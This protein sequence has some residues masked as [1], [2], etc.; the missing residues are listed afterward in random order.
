MFPHLLL[1][2][3]SVLLVRVSALIARLEESVSCPNQPEAVLKDT[4]CSGAF[5]LQV[6]IIFGFLEIFPPRHETFPTV[7]VFWPPR[8]FIKCGH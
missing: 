2:L 1:K 4:C 6:L 3:T 8:L 5:Y 7:L